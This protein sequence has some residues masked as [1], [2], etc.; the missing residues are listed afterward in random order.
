MANLAQQIDDFWKWF[1][2]NQAL[3]EAVIEAGGHPKTDEIVES[4]DQHILGMG[5][6][7]WQIGNP[8][9]NAFSF[10]LSPNNQS[11]IL[12]VTKAI[13]SKA[14]QSS[15][16]G[17]YHA[18][19]ATG[20]LQLQV[21]DHNMDVQNIDA[22]SWRAVIKNPGFGKIQLILEITNISHFDED[23]QTIAADLVL[24]ALLGE[25]KKINDLAGLELAFE[26]EDQH[27]YQAFSILELLG[28]LS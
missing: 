3:L 8:Q 2:N 25:E 26:L 4:L 27:K 6:I 5:K 1:E 20:E 17:F 10:T 24:N 15:Q 21:Y 22:N 11:E 13:I 7:K 14:P 28:R 12:K 18:A 16:W 9:P 19:P 23:T